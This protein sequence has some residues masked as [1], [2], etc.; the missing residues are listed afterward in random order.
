MANEE[1]ISTDIFSSRVAS[2]GSK[3]KKDDLKISTR[4]PCI[5]LAIASMDDSFRFSRLQS[6]FK[7]RNF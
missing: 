1:S 4:D 5:F 3:K 6:S 7:Q 2:V